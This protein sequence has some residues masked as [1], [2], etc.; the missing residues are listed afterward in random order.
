MD[1]DQD[2]ARRLIAVRERQKMSQV[3]FA[4][5]LHIAKNTLNGFERGKRSLTLETAKRIRKRF[6]ISVDWLLF[7]DIGQ[8][9]HAIAVEL[10]PVPDVTLDEKPVKKKKGRRAA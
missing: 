7:G 4:E 3:E 8:P 5:K 10:G 2:V 1:G 9:S 6:G